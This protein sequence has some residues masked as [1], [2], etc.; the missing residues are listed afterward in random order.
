M[1]GR[2]RY[3]VHIKVVILDHA[4]GVVEELLEAQRLAGTATAGSTERPAA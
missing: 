2:P 3:D 4:A 1:G